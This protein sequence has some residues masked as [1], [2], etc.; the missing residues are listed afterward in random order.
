LPP[1]FLSPVDWG[2]GGLRSKP[3]WG[4]KLHAQ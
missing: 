3:E 2:R 1:A 4:S